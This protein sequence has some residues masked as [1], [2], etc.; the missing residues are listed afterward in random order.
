M[1]ARPPGATTRHE[2]PLRRI[3]STENLSERRARN[4]LFFPEG[5]S[6]DRWIVLLLFVASCLYLRLFYD[7]TI[8]NADEGIVL[9]GAQRILQG[10][11]LYRDFFS[12]YTP[13]SYYW[14]ALL[15]KIFGSSILVGRAALVIYGGV[16]SVLTYLLARRVCA[17]WSA[18]FAAYLVTLVC[19]PFRFLVLHNWDSTLLAYLTVYCAMLLLERRHWAWALGTG[20]FAA[21]T[22]LFEHSKGTGLV[23]GLVVGFVVIAWRGQVRGS[24][25]TRDLTGLTAGFTWPFVVTLSYFAAKHSMAEMLSAWAWPVFHYSAANKLPYGYVVTSRNPTELFSGTWASRVILS[26]VMSPLLLFSLLPITAVVVLIWF[27]LKGP[28]AELST[29]KWGYWVLVSAVLS[30]LLLSTFLT[31][32]P[33]FTHLNYLGPVFYLVLAWVLDGLD[34]QSRLWRSLMPVL[35]LYVFL[36]FT[37]FGMMT[38]LESLSAHYKVETPRGIVRTADQDRTLEYILAHVKPGEKIFVYPYEALYYYLT[39]TFSPTRFDFLQ[40]GMHTADQFDKA[41]QELDADQTRVV[42]FETSFYDKIPMGWPDTPVQ[43]M[44]ARDPIENYIFA[45]YRPCGAP[46]SNGFWRFQFMVRKELPCP[47]SAR[48]Q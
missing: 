23:L 18:L 16:F 28:R 14:M 35:V 12:F 31:K 45:H 44:T 46:A 7:Y 1:T 13:G 6:R 9:Q 43:V 30:G 10:Q 41:L 21:L 26:V 5:S 29:Q 25:G 27:T 20:S 38:L 22:F 34:L 40:L 4:D 48:R 15:F 37:S 19:L 32:R 3:T 36:S 8:L 47:E 39:A 33:D 17:R 11:V 2:T 42:L 24:L